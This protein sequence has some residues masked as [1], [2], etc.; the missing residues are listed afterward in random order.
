M[1]HGGVRPQ[2]MNGPL[3]ASAGGRDDQRA[4][5]IVNS[6]CLDCRDFPSFEAEIAGGFECALKIGEMLGVF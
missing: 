2:A 6:P 4:S 5:S 3:F 1:T